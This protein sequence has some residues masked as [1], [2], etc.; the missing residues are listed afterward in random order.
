MKC[1]LD[2]IVAFLGLVVCLPLLLYIII[3]IRLENTG[4]IFYIQERLG[5]NSVPFKLIKFRTMYEAA[6]QDTPQLAVLGDKRIT[7][8]GRVLRK[9]HLDEIPQLWNVLR[10]EMSMVGPRPERAYFS[11]QLIERKPEC[12]RLFT[13]K[14]G[15]TSLGSVKYGYASSIDAM[16]E[17]SQ[18]ELYYVDNCSLL[19]D[20]RILIGTIREVFSGKGI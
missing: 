9:Y 14:P 13:V 6:E 4:S 8:F 1:L 16:I 17:R 19:M 20:F 11:K 12:V 3:R 7:P 5:K 15:V 18:Y 10:G 2:Y